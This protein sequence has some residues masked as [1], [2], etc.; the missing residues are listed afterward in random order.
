MDRI[1]R[2][3][4]PP[5]GKCDLK[6]RAAEAGV[7]RTGCYPKKNRPGIERPGPYQHLAEDVERRL[8]ALR[9]AGQVPDPRTAQFE[10]L[11]A[12]VTR[13]RSG[14]AA[15]TPLA[16]EAADP[17]VGAWSNRKRP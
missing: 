15:G 12:E 6:T 8:K 11:K 4:L 5:G 10:R 3:E 17:L 2:G 13:A 7:T 1:L 16:A 14:P 9:D